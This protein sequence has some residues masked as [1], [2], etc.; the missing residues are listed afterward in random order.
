[1]GYQTGGQWTGGF[2]G[3]SVT[4]T[5][6][7]GLYGSFTQGAI[8]VD[9]LAGYAYNANQMSRA[10]NIT[11]LQPRTAYGQTGANQFYGQLEAGWRV[12][13]GGAASYFIT[14]FA[15]LQGSTVTQNAFTET[16]A[17]SL[18]LSVAQQTTQSLRTVFGAQVGAAMDVG[19]RDKIAGQLRLGWSHEFADTARPVSPVRRGAGAAVHGVWRGTNAR[20]CGGG[21]LAQHG[22]C[23]GDGRLP[24]L[25]RHHRRPGLQPCPH[26]RPAGHV[27]S[28]LSRYPIEPYLAAFPVAPSLTAPK[29]ANRRKIVPSARSSGRP[30]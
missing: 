25:R 7:A 24:P 22:G 15:L 1:V 9:G 26:R 10:L 21:F 28:R 19:L 3:R 4:D 18:N 6:Q 13:L 14:P 16:G 29:A 8:Y 2:D 17:Q 27:V 20:R 30:L 12:E 5:F 23:R 11:G